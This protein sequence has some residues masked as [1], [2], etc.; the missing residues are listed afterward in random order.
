MRV[1]VKEVFTPTSPARIAFIDRE[2]INEK[3]VNALDMPG[4]Q[5]IVYGHSGSGKTTLLA[6]KLH[7]LYE[8][9]ITT[10]CMK[11]MTFD[12]IVLDAFDQLGAYFT[13]EQTTVNK[14]TVSADI[15]ASYLMIQNKI[16][17]STTTENTK[18]EQRVLP[19][20][21]TPQALG[22]FLGES[23]HCWIL[24]DFHKIDDAEKTRLS[25]LMKVFMDLSDHYPE[26]KIVAIGAVDTARQVVEYDSE[27]R[28][29]V[30]EVHVDLMTETEIESIV[31]KGEEALNISF[32]SDLKSLIA[33]YSNG[34]ASVCHHICM[35]MCQAAGVRETA[36]D[37]V[38]LSQSNFEAALRTYVEEASDSIRS[39]FDKA[40]KQRRKTKYEDVNIV[41]EALSGYS[42]RGA[43]RIPLLQKIQ[44]KVPNY[45][46]LN[47][48]ST[49]QKLTQDDYG[50]I[51]RYDQT[52]GLHSFSDPIYRVFALAHFHKNGNST[53]KIK[54]KNVDLLKLIKFLEVELKSIPS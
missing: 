6:N 20:Q 30:A 18:K 22:K 16:N 44:K 48:K 29:R 21:L 53:G 28:N 17:T 2:S 37:K 54:L 1:Q 40:F 4:K 42:E 41:L 15:A 26:L 24:E 25:Q 45:P 52:S 51:I 27:M 49:L 14:S 47:L 3:L 34:L 46:E 5:L 7:Q 36:V 31:S 10:H 35:Y 9:H 33:K 43:S 11:G 50:S 19:P 8:R 13:S 38:S 32:G 12:Q 39:A 23:K